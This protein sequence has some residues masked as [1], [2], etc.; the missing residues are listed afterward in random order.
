MGEIGR[1]E[2]RVLIDGG[3]IVV[4][5]RL[6]LRT[7]KTGLAHHFL[8]ALWLVAASALED[9]DQDVNHKMIRTDVSLLSLRH[10]AVLPGQFPSPYH[11][12]S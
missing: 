12:D 4:A 3:V 11:H 7:S 9:A 1:D 2:G 8:R 5:S 6:R 10:D